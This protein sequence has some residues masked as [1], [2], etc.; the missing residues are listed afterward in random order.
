MSL[1]VGRSE[2]LKVSRLLPLNKKLTAICKDKARLVSPCLNKTPNKY[3]NET[4]N[5]CKL[6]LGLKLTHY[7]ITTF[8]Q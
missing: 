5:L 1:I 2:G 7:R 6:Q 4:I 3:T 8:F